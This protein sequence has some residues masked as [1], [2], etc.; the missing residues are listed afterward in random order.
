MDRL[1]D[2]RDMAVRR[3][4]EAELQREPIVD[5]WQTH[6]VEVALVVPSILALLTLDPIPV[7]S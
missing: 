1:A 2:E 6:T 5:V 7:L 4:R 3:M